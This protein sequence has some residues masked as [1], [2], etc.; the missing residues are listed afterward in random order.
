VVAL[1]VLLDGKA[2]AE[3]KGFDVDAQGRGSAGTHRLYQLVRQR[4]V[5]A[6]HLFEIQFAKP[7]VCAY[8][9]TFG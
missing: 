2:P 8:A 7:G 1:R 6:E 3:N 5:A 4:A 9:F